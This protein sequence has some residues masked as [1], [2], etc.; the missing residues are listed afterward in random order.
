MFKFGLKTVFAVSLIFLLSFP[1][2]CETWEGLP[3]WEPISLYDC[4]KQKDKTTLCGNFPPRVD[5]GHDRFNGN[6]WI[7]IDG[8]EFGLREDG[9]VAWRKKR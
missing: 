8:M 4:R 2:F 5:W 9:V 1:A 7:S 6:P 3:D